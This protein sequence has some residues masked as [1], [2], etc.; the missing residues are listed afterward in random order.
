MKAEPSSQRSSSQDLSGLLGSASGAAGN[1]SVAGVSGGGGAGLELD[2]DSWAGMDD[3]EAA[4][5]MRITASK[6]VAQL[7]WK[8]QGQVGGG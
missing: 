6:A 2:P 3:Q 7:C 1:G 8:L 5:R 4:V